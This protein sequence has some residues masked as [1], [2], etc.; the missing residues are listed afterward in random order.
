M[1]VPRIARSAAFAEIPTQDLGQ[2]DR[3]NLGVAGIMSRLPGVAEALGNLTAALRGCG[4]LP[5]R[6]L[7]LVRLR[8]AFFNQCRSCIAVR[9]ESAIADGLDEA[10]VCSLE[11]PAEAE[12]LSAAERSALRFAELFATDHLAIDDAV[13]DEL[14]EHFTEDQLVELGLHCAIALGIGRLSATWDVSDDLPEASNSDGA[15][16]P[17]NSAS[18]VA[19]G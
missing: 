10:A 13:Y 12:N 6:L 14:R 18:V 5:P 1:K 16:A 9:Y 2:G 3:I 8:I 7:E 17:W 19:S 4:T 15:V 11:R